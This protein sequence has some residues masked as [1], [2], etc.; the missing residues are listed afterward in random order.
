[1]KKEQLLA[2]AAASLVSAAL[3]LSAAGCATARPATP[4]D[5]IK[6]E[7]KD[8]PGWVVKGCE[9]YLRAAGDHRACGVGSAPT[10]G[11]SL[12]RDTAVARARGEL[13]KSLQVRISGVLSDYQSEKTGKAPGVSQSVTDLTRQAT[14]AGLAGSRPADSFT[15]EDGTLYVLVVLDARAFRTSV[16]NAE[17]IPDEMKGVLSDHAGSIFEDK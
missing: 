3:A 2:L 17:G 16:A 10:K 12:A 13:S 15:S 5:A 6:S 9:P 11:N 8:A 14:A 1:M 7:L 4:G